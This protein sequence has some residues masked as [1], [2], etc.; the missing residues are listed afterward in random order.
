MGLFQRVRDASRQVAER[1]EYVRIDHERLAAYAGTLPLAQATA[2]DLDPASHYLG[3]GEGTLAFI[4]TLDTINFGSGYFPHLRKRPGMSGYFTVATA[5]AEHFRAHGPIPAA[6]LMELTTE[7]WSALYGQAGL[8][9]PVR[10]LMGLFAAALNDLGRYLLARFAGS[11]AALV[12]AAGG[13][14]EQ[15]ARLLVEMRFFDD[16]ATYRGMPVPFYKRAQLTA[17]DLALA[18]DGQGWGAF[19]DLD[20]LTIF[21]DNLVPHVLR[22]DGVLHYDPGLA[23]RIDR[24]EVI[25]A[26]A[27]EEVEIRARAVHAVDLLVGELRRVGQRVNAMGLGYLLWNRG[28]A[29]Y[30]KRVRPRHRTRTV[31]Y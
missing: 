11:F 16:V 2:P 28:Q 12:E 5:L 29:P 10:E 4:V 19:A 24:E 3:Q 26:G 20:S 15:L 6:R 31:Y 23:A 14:A 7:D 18:C 13:S 1:A 27:P 8:D 9:G 21:A 30:Y 25:P 22:V 17:A